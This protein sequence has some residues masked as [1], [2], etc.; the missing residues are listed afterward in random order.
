MKDIR[1]E[2][3][4]EELREKVHRALRSEGLL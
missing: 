3:T 1:G 4:L 2:Q